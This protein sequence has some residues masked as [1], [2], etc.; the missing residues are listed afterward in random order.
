LNT[1]KYISSGILEAYVLGDL[2]QAEK[3]EVE[4]M[5]SLYPEIRAELALIEDTMEAIAFRT[6]V[7]PKNSSK[8]KILA[9]VFAEEEQDNR[10]QEAPDAAQEPKAAKEISISGRYSYYMAAA[11]TFALLSS[12]AAFIFWGKW[13]EAE[14]R[15][16]VVVAERTAIAQ[17]YRTVENRLDAVNQQLAVY[18]NDNFSEVTLEGLA[19]APQAVATIFW[20][21]NTREVFLN[22]AGLPAIP[23][24]KQYQLWAIVDGQP[25]DI[26]LIASGENGGLVKMKQIAQASAFAITLEPS[27]GSPSPTLDQMVVLG[28]VS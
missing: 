2:T 1:E 20:N 14:S 21:K 22:P 28:K 17:R 26:G 9:K 15:L 11:V 19:L 16:S 7:A 25:V 18:T 10:L 13:Q 23:A 3:S 24:G 5:V 4:K 8:E 12:V 27:G 6:A